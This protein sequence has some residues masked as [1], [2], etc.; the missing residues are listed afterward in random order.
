MDVLRQRSGGKSRKRKGS[1]SPSPPPAT[2]KVP[3]LPLITPS[4]HVDL[5]GNAEASSSTSHSAAALQKKIQEKEA[6]RGFALA[7][8][9]KDLRPWYTKRPSDKDEETVMSAE[10]VDSAES[11]RRYREQGR[12]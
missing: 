12:K 3:D 6:E 4:G 9:K 10:D 11:A 8:D 5:F 7:P 1:R 2:F